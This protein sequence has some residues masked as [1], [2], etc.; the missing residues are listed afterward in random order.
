MASRSSTSTHPEALRPITCWSRSAED[1]LS[2]RP[3]TMLGAWSMR[4]GGSGALLR[5][6]RR[7]SGH[8]L[9]VLALNI[10]PDMTAR[11]RCASRLLCTRPVLV[12]VLLSRDEP[13]DAVRPQDG[14]RGEARDEEDGEDEQPV[15][16]PHRGAEQGAEAVRVGHVVVGADL[17][18]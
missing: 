10:N 4:S 14:V 9:L 15:D 11:C 2:R 17:E 7:P 3:L 8:E 5:L 6:S 1:Q 18:P 16:A 13:A 12:L